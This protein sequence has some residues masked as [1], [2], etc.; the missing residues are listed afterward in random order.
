MQAYYA[1]V[2]CVTNLLIDI[3]DLDYVLVRVSYVSGCVYYKV[4]ISKVWGKNLKSPIR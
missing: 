2:S 1:C 4:S 3:Y